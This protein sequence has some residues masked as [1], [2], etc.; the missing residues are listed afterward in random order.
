MDAKIKGTL[1]LDE[2]MSEEAIDFICYFS[3]SSAILGDFGSCDYAIANRFQ[4]AYAH[5]RNHLR[6][7]GQRQGKAIVINWPAWREGSMDSIDDESSKM[8]LKSSGQRFLEA[9]E[10]AALFDCLLAQNKTQHLVLVGQLSRV[11]RFLGLIQ[12]S[13]SNP[14]ISSG[15]PSASSGKGRREEMKGWSLE[16]CMEWDLKEHIG[17]LLK[18]P[19]NRLD[20]EENLADFGFDSISL[21]EFA[22]LLTNHYNIEIT[23]AL[24]F[25]HSTIKKLIRYF[26][27]EHQEAIR[28]FYQDQDNV[29]DQVL[30]KSKSVPIPWA[31]AKQKGFRKSA[32]C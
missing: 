7:Q 31:A 2:L 16:Q 11:H 14:V 29:P 5:Y 18:I 26:L 27:E 15:R 28:E 6:R 25:G 30:S 10:G 23:P 21:A 4:I 17:K 20:L 8:Y 22:A 19:R 13:G 3:S 9:E 12:D 24:F 32:F 1:I